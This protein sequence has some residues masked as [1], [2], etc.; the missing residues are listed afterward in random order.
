LNEVDACIHTPKNETY[1][2][3]TATTFSALTMG[4]V[5]YQDA[6]CTTPVSFSNISNG[7]TYIQTLN[8]GS[9]FNYGNC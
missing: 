8:D 1:Y 3:L 9:I 2:G 5:I 6:S 7:V 4:A